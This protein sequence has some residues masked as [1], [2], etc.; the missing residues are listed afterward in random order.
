MDL[1]FHLY[2][3][4]GVLQQERELTCPSIVSFPD[5]LFVVT[6]G[7]VVHLYIYNEYTIMTSFAWCLLCRKWRYL[8][9]RA[10]Y[11]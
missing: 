2:L 1:Y 9:S 11:N 10:R 6:Q 5:L 8:R 7:H 3:R 4:N